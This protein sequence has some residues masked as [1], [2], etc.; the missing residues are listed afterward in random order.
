M[1]PS[2]GMILSGGFGRTSTLEGNSQR[3]SQIQRENMSCSAIRD[4]LRVGE[5]MRMSECTIPPPLGALLYSAEP[6]LHRNHF[7][8]TRN[9]RR[10][11]EPHSRYGPKL[12]L[13]SLLAAAAS[14]S[15]TPSSS[16]SPCIPSRPVHHQ[17]ITR[18]NFRATLPE[19][20]LALKGCSFFAWDLEFSGLKVC[21]S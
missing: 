8:G 17:Q 12:G 7:M 16:G 19:V 18:H 15:S 10:F 1:I 5:T 4:S 11:K 20:E 2:V 9:R 6:A 3:F 21:Q 14:S 13:G